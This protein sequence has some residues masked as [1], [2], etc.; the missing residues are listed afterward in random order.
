MLT[1]HAENTDLREAKRRTCS[2]EP[3][4]AETNLR[5]TLGI[6]RFCEEPVESA[7]DRREPGGRALGELST[8]LA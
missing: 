2:G 5:E 1:L 6:L 7:I 8:Q 3:V 4:E